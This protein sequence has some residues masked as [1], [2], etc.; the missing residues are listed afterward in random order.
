[1]NSWRTTLGGAIGN[2]GKALAGVGV[3]AQF[4]DAP[5]ES[6]TLLWYTAFLGFVLTCVAGFVTS[7]FTADSKVLK[8]VVEQT[9]ANSS[10]I[11]QVKSDTA[12]I[13]K[14]TLP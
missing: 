13:K 10:E 11:S 2:L 12:F 7:L 8:Q 14:Q 9:N 6:K 4:T 5:P 3:L 1:M